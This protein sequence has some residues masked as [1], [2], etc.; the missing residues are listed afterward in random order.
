MHASNRKL[1]SEIDKLLMYLIVQATSGDCWAHGFR[2][3]RHVFGAYAESGKLNNVP[4]FILYVGIMGR[5]L[6]VNSVRVRHI[7]YKVNVCRIS[8]FVHDL[9]TV[10]WCNIYTRWAFSF[11]LHAMLGP[12]AFA[13]LISLPFVLLSHFPVAVALV[14][15][16][17]A[18]L[19]PWSNILVYSQLYYFLLYTTRRTTSIV[20]LYNG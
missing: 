3:F 7:N 8:E 17:A 14:H 18:F 6:V 15:F 5:A 11:V 2:C 20:L 4:L 10:L 9:R 12:S 19:R 13:Y 1:F 16:F